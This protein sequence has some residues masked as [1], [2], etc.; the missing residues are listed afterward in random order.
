MKKVIN[1]PNQVVEEMLHG[2]ALSNPAV[3]HSEGMGVISRKVKTVK[4][5]LLSGGGSGHEPA[6][7]GY[8]G[9]G[10]LDAAVSGNVFSSPDPMRILEGIRQANGGKGVLMIIKNYSGDCMNF[11]MA[12]SMAEYE[13][14]TVDY[15]IVKDDV[16]IPDDESSTGRRGIAGTVFV[17][18]IAGAKA[19][20]GAS[21]EEVKAIAEKTIKNVRT[22]GVSFSGCTIPAAGKP[23]F[24]L[25]DN[26]MEVGMGI[27]GERSYKTSEI[28][29]SKEIAKILCDHIIED[30]AKG[31]IDVKSGEFAVMINGLGSTPLMELCILNGDVQAYLAEQ[32][33]AVCKTFVGNYMTALE[34]TGV[35]VSLLKV[36]EDM[37][38]MLNAPSEA[39]GMTVPAA[40]EET[41]EL[42]VGQ[43]AV[44]EEA[45]AEE[46]GEASVSEGFA[47]TSA[48]YMEYVKNVYEK[49]V[50]NNE[51]ITELDSTVADGDHGV[52]MVSGFGALKDAADE[53]SALPVDQML[54]EIG[55]KMMFVVGG[56]SG[57]LYG[58][59]YIT[60]AKMMKG[61]GDMDVEEMCGVLSAMLEGIMDI[62]NGK[63][64]NSTMI[65]ALYPAVEC[66]KK[67][68][69]DGISEKETFALVKKAAID[70][71]EST[72]EMQCNRGR[73]SYL[74]NKGV[75]YLDPGAITMSYQIAALM[76]YAASKLN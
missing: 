37:K 61:R 33:I 20:A 31:G 14:I 2:L 25:G 52:N 19:E 42:F 74:E 11:K 34:M 59:A 76:D 45:A 43:T 57:V 70:G 28:K 17:H 29:T 65:D 40:S 26:E 7:A 35:S 56:S 51:Y 27:H 73:A 23:G 46:A 39:P 41:K 12:K 13:G 49:I 10:M 69:A 15:V 22:M 36:D 75:G 32:G 21:L 66:F 5:G 50:E 48:E 8:V 30:Y 1:D 67:C 6:H 53:L 64:G 4:V 71:A 55:K 44:K 63:P 3:I 18:K 68:L 16:A 58:N 54:L 9:K 62:G 60:A 47:I 72:K 24:V 38:A